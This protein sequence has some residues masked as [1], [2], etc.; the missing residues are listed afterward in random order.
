MT[1]REFISLIR[2]FA[3][4]PFVPLIRLSNGRSINHSDTLLLITNVAGI[5]YYDGLRLITNGSLR[6]GDRLVLRREPNN[7]YDEKAIEVY[8]PSGRKVGYIP[9]DV[10]E[11]PSRLMDQGWS[12]YAIVKEI[13]EYESP[14][15]TLHIMVFME[16]R[17][18]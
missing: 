13:R 3:L 9:R 1:R 4:L 14:Y 6:F 11:V 16:S 17:K 7:P 15:N 8:T 2:Y 18:G 12:L 10:N 5:Q